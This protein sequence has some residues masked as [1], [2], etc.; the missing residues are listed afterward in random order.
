M[1]VSVFK[2]MFHVKHIRKEKTNGNIIK[3]RIYEFSK[4]NRW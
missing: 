2:I 1:D 3:R 4:I